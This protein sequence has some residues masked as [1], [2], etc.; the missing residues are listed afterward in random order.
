VAVN[1]INNIYIHPV[2]LGN[3]NGQLPFF[4]PPDSE[5]GSGTFLK[6]E[7][8]SNKNVDLPLVIGDEWL[9]KN[10]TAHV[11][12]IKCDIEGYEKLALLGLKHTLENNRPIVVMELN[13]GLDESFRSIDD[14]YA[15]FPPDYEFLFFCMEDPYTGQ[16]KLCVYDDKLNFRE[17]GAYNIIVY[18]IEKKRLINEAYSRNKMAGEPNSKL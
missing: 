7:S 18:P 17:K 13:L 9:K 6:E 16:Y 1:H 4:E 10:G 2:G 11:D 15:T 5:T 3:E 8:T 12:I 14:F